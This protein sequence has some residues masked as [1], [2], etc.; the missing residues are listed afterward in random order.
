MEY[1]LIYLKRMLKIGF[2][3]AIK[4]NSKNPIYDFYAIDENVCR[5]FITYSRR[6]RAD[7]EQVQVDY[8]SEIIKFEESFD[9]K[10]GEYT[11]EMELVEEDVYPPI[12]FS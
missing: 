5:A 4:L 2:K 12:G 10:S 8:I 3:Y 7:V 6:T 1:Y 9:E 11:Y